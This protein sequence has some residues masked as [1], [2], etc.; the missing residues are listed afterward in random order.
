MSDQLLEAHHLRHIA[1]VDDTEEFQTLAQMMLRYLGV[2]Q[3]S[4]YSSAV[5]ALPRLIKA[6]PDALLLDLMMADMNGLKLLR[7]LRANPKTSAL[8]VVLCTAAINRVID[9]EEQ[10]QRDPHLQLL[11][12]PFSI[13]ELQE[14]LLRIGQPG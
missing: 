11:A 2:A 10:L 4:T 3:V 1:I 5:Q 14:V 7:K 12:K 6:P 9:E 8:P 13:E